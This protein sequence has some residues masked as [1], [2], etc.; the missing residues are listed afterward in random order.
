RLSKVDLGPLIAAEEEG[1]VFLDGPI[2]FKTVL[3]HL[4]ERLRQALGV[5]IKLAGVERIVTQEIED[6][7]VNLITSTTRCQADTRAAVAAHFGGG[8]VGCHLELLNV[9]RI[10]T[11][12]VAGGIGNGGF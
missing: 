1:L 11:I 10:E 4:Y 2:Q 8:V 3:M 6:G 9:I 12:E 5:E 7:A